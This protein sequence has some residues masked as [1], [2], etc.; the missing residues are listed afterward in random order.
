MF[1]KGSIY[2]KPI[3]KDKDY[4]QDKIDWLNKR[5]YQELSPIDYYRMMFPEGSFQA[6][7]ESN[8]DYKANGLLQFRNNGDDCNGMLNSIIYDDLITIQECIERKGRYSNHEF[9]TV[10]ACSYIGKHK[11][12]DN[13]RYCFAL[14]FDIDQVDVPELDKLLGMADA[15]L[16]PRPT[17]IVVSG[18]GVHVVFML[19]EPIRLYHKKL[20]KL[21]NIKSM[22]TRKLWNAH[23]SLDPNPQYQGITQGYRCVGT[24][25]KK[26]HMTRAYLTGSKVFRS[27]G[28]VDHSIYT[29][30]IKQCLNNK[31][32]TEEMFQELVN[33]YN[34]LT[35][36]EAK[37][38]YPKWYQRRILDNKPKGKLEFN[39]AVYSKWLDTIKTKASD[40]NRRRSIICLASCGQKCN[41]PKEQFE[42]DV[43]DLIPLF[44]SRTKSDDN[45]FK[46]SN[47]KSIIDTY[48]TNNYIKMKFST[49]EN[50]TGIA[51]PKKKVKSTGNKVGR[52]SQQAIIQQYL[53]NHPDITNKSQIA[54]E[55][56]CTRQ[57]VNKY[58][59]NKK[60]NNCETTI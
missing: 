23:T 19:Q 34:H 49:F 26:G 39:P 7:G 36:E 5:L 28:I 51:Y 14:I 37:D 15:D 18:N 30:R 32:L 52:P 24:Q 3:K 42:N 56:N 43:M 53:D 16:I 41:I 9:V 60:K 58:F 2:M 8:G 54:R 13:A 1:K 50:M 20:E 4:Y 33:D 29:E 38:M 46:Y 17:A 25:T 12:N 35:L 44:D 45:H 27:N 47:V 55:C 59:N 22:L 6:K 57:T 21:N 48:E 31:H 11:K 40:G 10:S